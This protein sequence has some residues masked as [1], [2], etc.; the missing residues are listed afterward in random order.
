MATQST[1]AHTDVRKFEIS[2]IANVLKNNVVAPF[3]VSVLFS[4][5]LMSQL[6]YLIK[7]FD[8]VFPYLI[9]KLLETVL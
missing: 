2:R 3:F 4:C 6:F 5:A 1:E 7:Q 8:I 9:L